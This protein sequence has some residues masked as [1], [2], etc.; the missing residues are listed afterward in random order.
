MSHFRRPA[1]DHLQTL[2]IGIEKFLPS[3]TPF[4]FTIFNPKNELAY[5]QRDFLAAFSE[6]N[7]GSGL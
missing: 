1:F 7:G 5:F 6:G 4:T 2:A 3:V